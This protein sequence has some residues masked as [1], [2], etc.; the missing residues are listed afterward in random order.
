MLVLPINRTAAFSK[1]FTGYERITS[2]GSLFT[3]GNLCPAVS[4]MAPLRVTSKLRSIVF[5]LD[6]VPQGPRSLWGLPYLLGNA[7]GA[8][9]G[10]AELRKPRIQ[11]IG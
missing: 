10:W 11:G 9:Q 2:P 3:V 7:T 1:G 5:M 4:E 6:L 8:L